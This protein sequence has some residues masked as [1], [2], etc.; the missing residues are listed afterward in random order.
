MNRTNLLAVVTCAVFS[1]FAYVASQAIADE[2][3]ES[4]TKPAVV[5]SDAK[6][7]L[8]VSDLDIQKIKWAELRKSDGNGVIVEFK[9]VKDYLH[10]D[11]KKTASAKQQFIDSQLGQPRFDAKQFLK[12]T[13]AEQLIEIRETPGHGGVDIYKDIVIKSDPKFMKEFRMVWPS[14]NAT[15]ASASCH[16]APEGK[17]E[18]KFFPRGGPNNDKVDYTNYLILNLWETKKGLQLIDRDYP[19]DSLVLQYGLPLD[20]A[21]DKHKVTP[22]WK[23]T[24]T[25]TKKGSNYA[26]FEQFIK[27]LDGT[28]TPN[29]GTEYQP[30]VG[31]LNSGSKALDDEVEEEESDDRD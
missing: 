30:P 10:N 23:A 26:K 25:D 5:V 18:L 16:G 22:R 20:K 13:T 4:A 1:L 19:E 9:S 14:V 6:S 12:L 15:C 17:G 24:F 3:G 21:K 29:Y 11:K 31:K 8:Y 7:D 27:D 28:R 2:A